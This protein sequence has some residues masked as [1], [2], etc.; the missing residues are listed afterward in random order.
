MKIIKQV[1]IFF[2][3]ISPL[4]SYCQETNHTKVLGTWAFMKFEFTKPMKDSLALIGNSKG[5]IVTFETENKVIMKRK[6]ENEKEIIRT[7]TYTLSEDG[8]SMFQNDV[9]A[10]ILSLTD[11]ELVMKVV[12]EGFIT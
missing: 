7:G 9:E 3:I 8:K 5:M 11:E 1:L 6:K 12:E 2:A 10:Q 4:Y